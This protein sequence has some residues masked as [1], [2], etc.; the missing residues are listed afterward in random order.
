[1]AVV[2]IVTLSPF[3]RGS[4][5][6]NAFYVERFSLF[7][8][9][10][11]IFP[12]DIQA[13]V[14]LQGDPAETDVDDLHFIRQADLTVHFYEIELVS[15]VPSHVLHDRGPLILRSRRIVSQQERIGRNNSF[16]AM[17]VARAAL[18]WL[19]LK[20]AFGHGRIGNI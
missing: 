11:Q 15:F 3:G 20:T 7:L 17:A 13:P 6:L 2:K 10:Q 16:I 5:P 1:M 9:L 18:A 14:H 12:A 4:M 19:I 8:E